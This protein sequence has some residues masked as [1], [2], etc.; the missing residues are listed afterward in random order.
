MCTS[1]FVWLERTGPEGSGCV[2]GGLGL[3]Q[4]PWRAHL[5]YHI[6]NGSD[7]LSG[8]AEHV[9]CSEQNGKQQSPEDPR[10]HAI[11]SKRCPKARRSKVSALHGKPRRPDAQNFRTSADRSSQILPCSVRIDRSINVNR[12]AWASI[13]RCLARRALARC[14]GAG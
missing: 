11:A 9:G 3:A 6:T 5:P 12:K 1:L 10:R 8:G 7:L 4:R 14:F 13:G 2:F